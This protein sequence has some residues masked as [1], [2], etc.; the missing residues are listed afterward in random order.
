MTVLEALKG[1]I[2]FEYSNND[3]FNLKLMDQGL[4]SNATFRTYTVIQRGVD[5]ALADVYL[6]L[7]VHPKASEGDR[8]ISFDGKELRAARRRLFNK[9]GMEPPESPTRTLSIDGLFGE[10]RKW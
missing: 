2:E 3:L 7:A 5:L 6:H 4:R 1:L 10:N 8:S 9:W